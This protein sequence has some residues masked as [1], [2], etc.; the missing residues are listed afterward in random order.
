MNLQKGDIIELKAGHTVYA[1]VPEHFCYENRK[2]SFKLTRHDV[3][4]G[5]EFSYLAGRYAVTRTTKDGGGTGHGPHDIYPDGHHV[6]CQKL[7]ESG[8]EVDF[9]QSGAFTAMIKEI[10]PVGKAKIKWVE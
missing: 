8:I 7:D 3:V 5:G 10:E 4:I 1:Q 2:G 9:Y 6:F